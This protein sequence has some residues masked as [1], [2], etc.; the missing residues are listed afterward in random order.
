MDL[1]AYD[2]DTERKNRFKKWIAVC[3]GFLV[4]VMVGCMI[5]CDIAYAA[6]IVQVESVGTSF[7]EWNFSETIT[8]TIVDG[9]LINNFNS[10][11]DKFILSGL[12]PESKHSIIVVN[13]LGEKG[14]NATYT[15][16]EKTSSSEKITDFVFEY[17]LLFIT[18]ILLLVGFKIPICGIIGFIF[19]FMGLI[20]A[21]PKGNYL[22][23]IIFTC[24]M[25]GA[26]YITYMGVEH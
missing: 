21:L 8:Y 3:I 7:I 17:L 26:V 4:L 19:S 5:I 1:Y 14:E 24:G 11:T 13:E 9:Q 15:L 22:L 18:I 16:S 25:I 2:L 23:D 20:S 6:P 10:T 12:E